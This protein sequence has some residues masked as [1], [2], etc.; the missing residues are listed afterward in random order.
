[1]ALPMLGELD[2]KGEQDHDDGGGDQDH[3]S[4]GPMM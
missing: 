4:G 3:H 2:Q 1:M